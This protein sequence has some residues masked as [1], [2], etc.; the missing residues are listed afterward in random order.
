MKTL[1]EQG[2]NVNQVFE[3]RQTALHEASFH[4][5]VGCMKLLREKGAKIHALDLWENAPIHMVVQPRSFKTLKTI[6]QWDLTLINVQN[7]NGWTPLH[8]AIRE[9]LNAKSVIK[10]KQANALQ[11]I[12]DKDGHTADYYSNFGR[13]FYHKDEERMRDILGNLRWFSEDAIHVCPQM[14]A[15]INLK[16]AMEIVDRVRK[17]TEAP[18]TQQDRRLVNNIAK[19]PGDLCGNIT[20]FGEAEGDPLQP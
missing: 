1:L 8:M 9:N 2:A 3:K 5:Q 17:L 11:V 6:M 13:R 16:D 18:N 19:L 14:R 20:E 7:M 15:N 12:P 4:G 10:L